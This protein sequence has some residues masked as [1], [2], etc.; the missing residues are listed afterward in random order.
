MK[1]H[2]SA[3]A[4][5]GLL[6]LASGCSTYVPSSKAGAFNQS[7]TAVAA[8]LQ[9][10]LSEVQSVEID[11][12]VDSF[13][14]GNAF[15]LDGVDLDPKL[16]DAESKAL[17]SQFAYLVSYSLAL[18]NV[19]T[20][21]TAWE[22]SMT[23]LGAAETKM[24]TDAGALSA[25]MGDH[26]LLTAGNMQTLN[27]DAGN[28][29]KAV[30]TLG[31]GV[32]TLYGEDKAYAI[33]HEVDPAVQAYCTDLEALLAG[34]PGD[35]TP[36]TGLAGILHADYEVEIAA[37]KNLTTTA[38]PPRSYDDPNYLTAFL[39]RKQLVTDY[40]ALLKDEQRGVAKI[41]A[42]RK[43]VAAIASAHAA[44]AG[45]DDATFWQELSATADLLE[46]AFKTPPGDSTA[47]KK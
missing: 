20:P 19:T 1:I 40:S 30:S 28:V 44:L 2:L 3:L 25:S 43:A 42:L 16:S 17:T 45:K 21:G 6:G 15:K 9:E 38:A 26:A 4:A 36:R 11:N 27:K 12:R 14:A 35:A 32:L 33:A 34:D 22:T 31:Q 23:S 29:S 7:V 39:S 5:A 8:D 47:A 41:V 46:A 24:G 18:K 37:L 13:A 10:S